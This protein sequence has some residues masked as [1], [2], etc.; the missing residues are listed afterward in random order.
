M[1]LILAKACPL[2]H[3]AAPDPETHQWFCD[4]CRCT[5]HDVSA[6]GEERAQAL[7]DQHEPSERICGEWHADATGRVLFNVTR[8]MAAAAAVVMAPTA[9]AD[10]GGADVRDAMD[11]IRDQ[12]TLQNQ[13]QVEAEPTDA[14][15]SQGASEASPSDG[16]NP[17]TTP[18][19]VV[20]YRG[21]IVD[22]P[23]NTPSSA[24]PV[25]APTAK[26]TEN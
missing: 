12:Q 9:L 8:A 11:L 21:F 13:A 26:T 19:P 14:A 25:T 22:V 20:H 4:R 17:V 3:G 23:L 1:R 6:M 7:L 2:T 18:E 10:G 5:V 24:P 16:T 15:P